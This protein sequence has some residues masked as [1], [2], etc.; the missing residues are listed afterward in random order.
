MQAVSADVPLEGVLD[1]VGAL[2]VL[3]AVLVGVGAR[4]GVQ[5]LVQEFSHVV[6]QGQDL[7]VLG[8]PGKEQA[9]LV[10]L[11]FGV[12]GKMCCVTQ[13]AS[14]GTVTFLLTVLK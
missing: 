6:G 9:F 10:W 11:V 1:G 14:F 12:P 7:E 4:V 13:K 2:E 3:L 8:V 5:V